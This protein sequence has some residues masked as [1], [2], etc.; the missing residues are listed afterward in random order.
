[1]DEC[2]AGDDDRFFKG[3]R[4]QFFQIV[5]RDE[6]GDLL[7]HRNDHAFR[8]SACAEYL[9]DVRGGDTPGDD[10][11]AAGDPGQMSEELRLV[12]D[13]KRRVKGRII[14]RGRG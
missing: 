10:R 14:Q 11:N 4:V 7:L 2:P 1:M 9:S 5:D 6:A 8:R 3:F 12:S 13:R